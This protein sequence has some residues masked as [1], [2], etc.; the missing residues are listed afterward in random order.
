LV[1]KVPVQA[2]INKQD[3]NFGNLIP[4]IVDVH[5]AKQESVIDHQDPT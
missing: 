3:Q 1:Q 2:S 5:K 4:D